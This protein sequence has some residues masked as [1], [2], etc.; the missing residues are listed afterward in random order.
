M[1][2]VTRIVDIDEAKARLSELV[3]HAGK[4]EPFIIA[5]GGKPMV[6][7]TAINRPTSEKMRRFGFM[8]GQIA[9]PEDFDR[10]GGF[11]N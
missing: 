9:I 6:E 5:K 2:R 4:G 1:K 7:V 3:D 10:M 11:D 8:K